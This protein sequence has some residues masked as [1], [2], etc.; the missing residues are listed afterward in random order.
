MKWLFVICAPDDVSYRKQEKQWM[1][2]NSALMGSSI[3]V[4]VIAYREAYTESIARDIFE[5][6]HSEGYDGV[7]VAA[8]AYTEEIAGR[9]AALE[10]CRCILGIS[11]I[12]WD[13][14]GALFHKSV[15]Q[16]NMEAVFRLEPPFALGLA[17]WRDKGLPAYSKYQVFERTATEH[18]KDG[19]EKTLIEAGEQQRESDVLLVV[20]KGVRCRED[21]QKIKASAIDR[22]YM[23]GVTRPVAMNGWALIDEIV[24]VSGHIYS[25]EI[26]ITIGV[27]GSAA[28]YA[29]IENSG[30]IASVNIDE[31][32]PI[33]G[34][35]D[36]FVIDD[37]ENIWERLFRVL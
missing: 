21:V 24:G 25:P 5:L 35:S 28:F 32:A 18:F 1:I 20:G 10:E 16:A 6:D 4:T 2:I 11:D 3:S 9:Y 30:W 12:T 31:H 23:F 15:Y 37:Y 19:A 36:V 13:G 33:I 14:N 29:G 7:L 17:Q 34:M 27:S 26:C 8:G 22:G